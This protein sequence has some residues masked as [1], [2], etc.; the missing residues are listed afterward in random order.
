MHYLL[1]VP[2]GLGSIAGYPCSPLFL[3]HCALPSLQ[4]GR[5][6]DGVPPGRIVAGDLAQGMVKLAAQ[7]A[8]MIGPHVT[9]E[10]GDAMQPPCESFAV[11]FS[12]FGLQQL[13]DPAVAVARWV[14]D[15]ESAVNVT[16]VLHKRGEHAHACRH[17][18]DGGE[19]HVC[20]CVCVYVCMHVCMYI[21]THLLRSV[22]AQLG[23]S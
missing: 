15:R 1:C 17:G 23:L 11:I 3:C 6:E 8:A 18:G 19:A 13:P 22:C 9:V 10:V 12:V 7:K 14:I 20:T 4:V 2:S 5:A 16:Q 21:H